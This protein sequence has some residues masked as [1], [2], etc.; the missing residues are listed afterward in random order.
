MSLT[1]ITVIISEIVTI[2]GVAIPAIVWLSRIIEG[3][4][5]QLRA[6]MLSIY[7]RC[8]DTEEIRQYEAEHFE[9]CYQAYKALKGN[10]FID[11]IYNKAHK[12]DVIP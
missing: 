8:K 2:T 3:Q 5:C 7:Y 9:K 11:E 1:T 4:R 6:D 12:W 10:S